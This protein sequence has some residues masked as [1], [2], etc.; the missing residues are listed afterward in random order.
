M[1]VPH[2]Q[3]HL[4]GKIPIDKMIVAHGTF[5]AG[6]RDG[7]MGLS[8]KSPHMALDTVGVGNPSGKVPLSRG[9]MAKE[10]SSEL[11]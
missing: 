6:H 9:G 8:R 3:W 5:P 11:L 4:S 7:K 10:M 1:I 2:G